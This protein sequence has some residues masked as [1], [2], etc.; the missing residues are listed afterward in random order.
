MGCAARDSA[1]TA[2]KTIQLRAGLAP[3]QRVTALIPCT[4]PARV[5]SRTQRL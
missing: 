2:A 5:S 3:N 4:Q 1:T